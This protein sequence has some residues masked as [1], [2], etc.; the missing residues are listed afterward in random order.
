M[1]NRIHDGSHSSNQ[2]HY[3]VRTGNICVNDESHEMAIVVVS[4][5]VVYPGAMMV[6]FQYTASTITTMMTSW[7]FIHIAAFAVSW[8][9]D[10]F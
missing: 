10:T 6:H 5:T 7:W 1:S 2:Q 4:N 8:T 9:S 3:N